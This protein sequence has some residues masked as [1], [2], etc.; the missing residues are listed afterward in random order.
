[1]S[2]MTLFACLMDYLDDSSAPISLTHTRFFICARIPTHTYVSEHRRESA[3]ELS[4][5]RRRRCSSGFF[6]SETPQLGHPSNFYIPF[7]LFC[8]L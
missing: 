8:D 4:I 1:M 2:E 3:D 6:S 5:F 7:S